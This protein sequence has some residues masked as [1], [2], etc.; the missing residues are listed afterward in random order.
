MAF[1]FVFTLILVE[2]SR[3][4]LKQ[5]QNKSEHRIVVDCKT[6]HIIDILS[7]AKELKLL[8]PHFSYFLTSLVDSRLSS[9]PVTF[10]SRRTPTPSTSAS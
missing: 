1:V 10:F 9:N 6:E 5:I 3:S 2:D 4:A 7:Q 8:E